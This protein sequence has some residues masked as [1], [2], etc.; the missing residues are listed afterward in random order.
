MKDANKMSNDK[1]QNIFLWDKTV[2]ELYKNAENNF[3]NIIV[4]NDL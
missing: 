3:Q 4:K 2:D 1:F